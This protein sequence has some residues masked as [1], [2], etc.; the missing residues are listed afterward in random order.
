MLPTAMQ[1]RATSLIEMLVVIGIIS[2]LI[3]LLLP[4]VQSPR[5]AALRTACENNLH[6]LQ[7]SLHHYRETWKTVPFTNQTNFPGGWAIDLLPFLEQSDLQ[8]GIRSRLPI[9]AP[10]NLELVRS[11]PKIMSCPVRSK[12]DSRIAGIP[13]AEYVLV[14]RKFNPR[15]PSRP[16]RRG[17]GGKDRVQG[18][19]DAPDNFL[20]PWALSPEVLTAQAQQM[21]E[22][23]VGPHPG[24]EILPRK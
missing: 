10:G 18:F 7:I 12:S 8:R 1:R 21:R 14:V 24:G 3:S 20:Q 15:Q 9:D 11:L 2:I 19:Q 6:Q 22:Q 5:H 13:A 16:T 4:A 23:H 17:R